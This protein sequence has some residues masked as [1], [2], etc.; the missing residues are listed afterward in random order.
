M[1]LE[2]Y[3]QCYMNMIVVYW[4]VLKV[5]ELRSVHARFYTNM[6]VVL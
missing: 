6:T 3:V 5:D 4:R 1:Y 2:S